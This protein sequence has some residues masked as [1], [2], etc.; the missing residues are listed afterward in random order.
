MN[1]VSVPWH[2]IIYLTAGL[3]WTLTQLIG[4]KIKESFKWLQQ[5]PKQKKLTK[6]THIHNFQWN[7]YK[8]M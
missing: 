3:S 5:Q 8:I 7:N 6:I 2:C 1:T 4:V